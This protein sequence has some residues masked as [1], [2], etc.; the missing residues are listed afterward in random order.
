MIIGIPSTEDY[1]RVKSKV[2]YKLAKAFKEALISNKWIK[3]EVQATVNLHDKTGNVAGYLIAIH[4][5][6]SDK[7]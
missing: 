4:M 3:L 5:V 2:G 7:A 6:L 1:W